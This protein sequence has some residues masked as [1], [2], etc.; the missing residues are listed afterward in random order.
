MEEK[1][2][3]YCGLLNVLLP[4]WTIGQ[5]FSI[6]R[7]LLSLSVIYTPITSISLIILDIVMIIGLVLL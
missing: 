4:L 5:I 3:K 2:K 7:V 1:Q 6:I